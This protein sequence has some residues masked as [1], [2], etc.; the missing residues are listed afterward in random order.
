LKLSESIII[1]CIVHEFAHKVA[2]SGKTNLRE[3][4]AEELLLAWGFEKESKAMDYGR[5]ILESEGYKIG[6]EWAKG[7][8]EEDL[9][10]F[11]RFYHE[12]N[13]DRL[14]NKRLEMLC[15]IADTSSIIEA[16]GRFEEFKENDED[17]IPEENVYVDDDF[18][19]KG[20]IWGIMGYLKEKKDLWKAGISQRF[21]GDKE[22]IVIETLE[23][24]YHNCMSLFDISDTGLIVRNN[25]DRYP[26]MKI[27]FESLFGV[28]IFLDNFKK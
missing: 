11:E 25:M 22:A 9:E 27:F 16:M 23:K 2:G 10:K 13:E 5:P 28:R 8:K 14:T 19:D 15:Y 24:A 17:T 12:W 3:K 21:E 4:E 1:H 7:Q 6:Y 20:I 26:E 18:F